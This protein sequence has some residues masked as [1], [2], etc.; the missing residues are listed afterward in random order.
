M[1]KNYTS[2]DFAKFAKQRKTV[3]GGFKSPEIRQK[4]LETRLKNKAKKGADDDPKN[5]PEVRQ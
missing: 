1:K 2:K 4:A 5:V 3:A